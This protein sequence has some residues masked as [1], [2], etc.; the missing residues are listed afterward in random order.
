VTDEIASKYDEITEDF[1]KAILRS[2]QTGMD[3]NGLFTLKKEVLSIKTSAG[4][5]IGFTTLTY[6]IGGCVKSGPTILLPRYRGMGYGLAARRAIESYAAKRDIRKLYCTCPDNDPKICR[7]LIRSGFF[8]EAHLKNHYSISHGEFVFGKFLNKNLIP[9]QS[10]FSGPKLMT[11]KERR[12]PIV[13][14]DSVSFL[15]NAFVSYWQIDSERLS[16]GIFRNAQDPR[17]CYEQKPVDFICLE[18]GSRIIGAAV[19]VRKRGGSV[20]VLW[21]PTSPSRDFH[22]M[23]QVIESFARRMLRRKIY[24]VHPYDDIEVILHLKS[25]GYEIEGILKEPYSR[26]RDAVIVSRFIA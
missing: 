24:F 20:K 22:D 3:P 8:V 25:T 14:K 23:I 10:D 13:A 12:G 19:F 16:Q 9:P 2:H 7:H 1:A 18:K 6:K 15:R 26:G 17:I 11:Q 5:R 4:V 21:F